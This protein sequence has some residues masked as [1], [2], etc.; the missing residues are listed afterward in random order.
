MLGHRARSYGSWNL[1]TVR[2]EL[3]QRRV[4]APENKLAKRVH[5]RSGWKFRVY[6]H[7]HS[8]L[9]LQLIPK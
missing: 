2:L 4:R 8:G 1:S 5:S 6:D 7:A 3:W 9:E